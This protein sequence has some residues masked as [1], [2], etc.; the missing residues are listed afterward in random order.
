MSGMWK[1]HFP[2]D[3][4]HQLFSKKLFLNKNKFVQWG[5]IAKGF[6]M[7]TGDKYLRTLSGHFRYFLR[8]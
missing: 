7:G 5:H 3:I 4:G 6:N 1:I 8:P 2:P